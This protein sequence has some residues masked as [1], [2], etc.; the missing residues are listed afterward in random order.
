[1]KLRDA[2]LCLDCDEVHDEGT[3]PSC[4]SESFAFLSRWVP[5]PEGNRAPRPASSEQAEVYRALLDEQRASANRGLLRGGLLGLTALGLAG[6][7]WRRSHSSETERN[8][9]KTTP[10]DQS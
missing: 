7:A 8:R 6:W 9:R 10:E 2:R 5:A 4:S 1:M 3:C